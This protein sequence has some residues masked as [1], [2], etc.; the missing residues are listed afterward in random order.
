MNNMAKAVCVDGGWLVV[1]LRGPGDRVPI[2][3]ASVLVLTVYHWFS[4]FPFHRHVDIFGHRPFLFL[5][6]LPLIFESCHCVEFESE[7]PF[8]H[9]SLFPGRR[10]L[11]SSFSS[12][13][14][15][16]CQRFRVLIAAVCF[17]NS[18]PVRLSEIFSV[19]R[20]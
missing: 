4:L 18:E 15:L 9:T 2:L 7:I 5:L 8:L 13:W 10:V 20:L 6:D 14:R 17:C 3:Q 11:A 16:V 12:H 19:F 1:V